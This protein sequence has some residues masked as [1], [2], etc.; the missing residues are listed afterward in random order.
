MPVRQPPVLTPPFNEA[1]FDGNGNWTASWAKFLDALGNQATVLANLQ[2][3]NDYGD[4]AAAAA[5]GVGIGEFFLSGTTVNK[6]VA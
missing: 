5:G 6:R 1:P 3:T 2:I 4:E